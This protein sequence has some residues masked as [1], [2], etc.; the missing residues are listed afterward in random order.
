[1]RLYHQRE[2]VCGFG[3]RD[4]VTEHRSPDN[5]SG[6]LKKVLVWGNFWLLS[7]P[8]L[9]CNFELECNACSKCDEC[10][11]NQ[12]FSIKAIH[13]TVLII[14]QKMEL[15]IEIN[16]SLRK[17]LQYVNF[18]GVVVKQWTVALTSFTDSQ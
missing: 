11:T 14:L 9:F 2:R 8:S 12:N 15:K 3:P 7:R 1:M 17:Q 13:N 18:V 4:G 5:G 6:L 10:W 16:F